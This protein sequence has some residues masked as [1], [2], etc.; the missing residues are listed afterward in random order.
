M[1][2][3][4][5]KKSTHE[6]N[7]P[8]DPLRP[9][10]LVVKARPD[11]F[12]K[13]KHVKEVKANVQSEEL[14][15]YMTCSQPTQMEEEHGTDEIDH[16]LV[17]QHQHDTNTTPTCHRHPL[18]LQSTKSP[19]RKRIYQPQQAGL[20]HPYNSLQGRRKSHLHQS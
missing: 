5:E 12:A 6:K 11:F 9:V 14:F 17:Q 8:R 15:S 2:G 16:H 13:K 20:V 18:A 19:K 4:Q 7:T 10:C 1:P 3:K